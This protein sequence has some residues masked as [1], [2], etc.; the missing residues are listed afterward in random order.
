MVPRVTEMGFFSGPLLFAPRSLD[1]DVGAPPVWCMVFCLLGGIQVF[2]KT[3]SLILSLV[4]KMWQGWVC[5]C[6]FCRRLFLGV[7]CFLEKSL[8]KDPMSIS[9]FGEKCA[10]SPKP[11][12]APMCGKMNQLWLK[13][14]CQ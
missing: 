13:R 5:V 8:D 2:W 10:S 14:L 9:Q 11:W 4:V 7:E 6:D 12:L 1:V 3:T